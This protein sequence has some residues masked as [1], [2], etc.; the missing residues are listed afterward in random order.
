MFECHQKSAETVRGSLLGQVSAPECKSCHIRSHQQILS[1]L[2]KVKVVSKD[3]VKGTAERKIE[4]GLIDII[5]S[6]LTLFLGAL[7]YATK[8][9][10]KK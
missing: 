8:Y 6:L 9:I 1:N 2:V 4:C 5:S 3:S 10:L 7:Y